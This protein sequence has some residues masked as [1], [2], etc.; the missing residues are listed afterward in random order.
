MSNKILPNKISNLTLLKN[1]WFQ[2][3]NFFIFDYNN[4]WDD[5]Y[6]SK[7]VA[8]YNKNKVKNIIIRSASFDEDLDNKTNAWFFDSSQS[9]SL[10]GLKN[11]LKIYW[12]KNVVKVENNKNLLF[13]F[14]QEFIHS[15]FSW[16]F[17]TQSPF[18][19][20]LAILEISKECEVITRGGRWGKS[21]IYEKKKWKWSNKINIDNKYI[22]EIEKLITKVEVNFPSWA[23]IEL[24]INRHWLFIFQIRDI[25]R[26]QN[27]KIL[28]TE[29]L[30]LSRLYWKSFKNQLWQKNSFIEAVWNL[31]PLSLS[32]YNDLLRSKCLYNVLLNSWFIDSRKKSPYYNILENIWGNTYYNNYQDQLYFPKRVWKLW[33]FKTMFLVFIKQHSVK[34]DFLNSNDNSIEW[35]FSNLFL[36][37]LYFSFFIEIKKNKLSDIDFSN[38]LKNTEELCEAQFPKCSSK[39]E[40]IEKYYYWWLSPY[41][42]ESKRFDEMCEE[43]IVIQNKTINKQVNNVFNENIQFWLKQKIK[44]KN[45]FLLLIYDLRNEILQSKQGAKLFNLSSYEK[46]KAKNFNNKD[47]NT[48]QWKI[49]KNILFEISWKDFPYFSVRKDDKIVIVAWIIKKW[50]MFL[51]SN[52]EISNYFWK[53]I[54]VEFFNSDWIPL[55]PKFTWIILKYWSMLSHVSITCREYEIP[56]EIDKIFFDKKGE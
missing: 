3:P 45:K 16:V 44:W 38:I 1:L 7:V 30:R 41:A 25:I 11:N 13:L 36:A 51:P 46:Y 33:Q 10:K 31:Q 9:L 49:L 53:T 2:V 28:L 27:E 8:F 52:V 32:L 42:L 4:I 55:I 54:A 34:N 37:G 17:F 29:K 43:D 35:V 21:F 6:I 19:K 14:V 50:I 48:T 12:K 23:D 18:D 22:N 20:W 40:F 15:D 56:C 47:F 5:E 39:K 26:S 24:W